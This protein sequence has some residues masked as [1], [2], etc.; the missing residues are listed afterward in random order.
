MNSSIIFHLLPNMW[1]RELQFVLEFIS[2]SIYVESIL[3]WCIVCLRNQSLTLTKFLMEYFDHVIR[4]L[5]LLNVNNIRMNSIDL[6]LSFS[7][8]TFTKNSHSNM[9]IY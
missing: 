3:V 7:A 5:G 8:K 2:P 6:V 9:C 4:P 1:C